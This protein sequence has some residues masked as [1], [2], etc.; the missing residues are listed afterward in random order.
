MMSGYSDWLDRHPD[1]FVINTGRTPGAAY[2]ML[3]RAGCGTITGNPA[4]GTT[5]TGDYAKVC[6]EELEEFA[7]HLGGHAKPCGL[8]L[9]RPGSTAPCVSTFRAAPAPVSGSRWAA[10]PVAA[11]VAPGT[12][13]HAASREDHP[14]HGHQGH[15][16]AGY[17]ARNIRTIEVLL[18]REKVTSAAADGEPWQGYDLGH[19]LFSCISPSSARSAWPAR[20]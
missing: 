6:G 12:D 9:A 11:A 3:H 1:G 18:D 20:M 8:C 5:F 7:R 16:E 10:C 4:R 14:E 19:G 13:G 17:F 15:A 2:L